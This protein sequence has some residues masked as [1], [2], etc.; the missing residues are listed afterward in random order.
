MASESSSFVG[1]T[2]RYYSAAPKFTLSS[3]VGAKTVYIKAKNMDGES[4]VVSD[5]IVVEGPT[6][7]A[8]QINSG[9]SSTASRTA[10]LNSTVTN[11]PTYFMASE[12]SSF[13]GARWRYY[14]AAPRFTLS[15]GAGTKTIYFKV[16]NGVGESPVVTDTITLE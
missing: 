2:W 13:V 15:V 10:T 11:S 7:S 6:V 16:L 9:A 4:P 1:A 12:S 5:T 14:S 8:F 3:G